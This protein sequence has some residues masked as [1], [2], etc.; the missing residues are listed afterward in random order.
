MKAMR[1]FILKHY[2]LKT[3]GDNHK[4][5]FSPPYRAT[6]TTVGEDGESPNVQS[7]GTTELDRHMY[8]RQISM[9]RRGDQNTADQQ[10]SLLQFRKSL[11]SYAKR[12]KILRT[13]EHHTITIICGP[14]G[15]GKT[16]QVPQF[17]LEDMIEALKG[18]KCSII[19]TQPRRISAVSVAERVAKERGE[20]IGSTTGYHIRLESRQSAQT[21]LL[22][23]TVGV[24]L[25]RLSDDP[26]LRQISHVIVDEVHERD[27]L[28]DFLL[29]VLRDLIISGKR[30]DLKIILMSATVDGDRFAEYFGSVVGADK[31]R[32]LSLEG[33]AFPVRGFFKEEVL[34]MLGGE[35]MAKICKRSPS[36][37][38]TPEQSE[39]KEEDI[40][41]NLISRTVFHICENFKSEGA[42]LIFL[43]GWKEITSLCQMINRNNPG[44]SIRVLPLHS[45]I[46]SYQQHQ[47][48]DVM[49][50]GWRKVVVATNIAE[51]SVT[52][53]DV[54]FVIDSGKVNQLSYNTALQMSLLTPQWISKAATKQREGRA[55]RCQ[56]GFVFRMFTSEQ[57]QAFPEYEVPEMVRTPLE[58]LCLQVKLQTDVDIGR[59][60]AKALDPPAQADIAR[61]VQLLVVLGALNHQGEL[62]HLGSQLARLPCHPRIGKM[63]LFG[64]VFNCLDPILTIACCLAHRS[65][66]I[67]PMPHE[68]QAAQKARQDF[69]RSSFSDQITALRAFNAWESLPIEERRAYSR[70][71]YL[72]HNTLTMIAGIKD[73]FRKALESLGFQ[74]EKGSSEVDKNI[75]M[76]RAIISSGMS[77]SVIEYTSKLTKKGMRVE[78]TFL[79]ESHKENVKIHPGSVNGM[80]PSTFM[81]P[82]RFVCYFQMMETSA[83][84]L[85]T[86]S[87][88]STLA[89]TIFSGDFDVDRVNLS[90]ECAGKQREDLQLSAFSNPT[91]YEI[92]KKSGKIPTDRWKKLIEELEHEE[93][94]DRKFSEVLDRVE[95]M[96]VQ[97]QEEKVFEKKKQKERQREKEAKE[98]KRKQERLKQKEAKRKQIEE[99]NESWFKHFDES[100]DRAA[101]AENG[102]PGDE[103]EE[104]ADTEGTND[105]TYSKAREFMCTG[106]SASP[107]NSDPPFMTSSCASISSRVGTVIL[108]DRLNPLSSTFPSPGTN[109]E[110]HELTVDDLV[111]DMEQA[112]EDECAHQEEESE[113]EEDGEDEKSFTV[114]EL[115][116][117]DPYDTVAADDEGAEEEGEFEDDDD[118]EGDDSDSDSDSNMEECSEVSEEE[119]QKRRDIDDDWHDDAE[120][121]PDEN[122]H[123]DPTKFDGENSFIEAMADLIAL[124]IQDSMDDEER[125]G[126]SP[127]C[128][129]QFFED[130]TPSCPPSRSSSLRQRQD[131]SVVMVNNFVEIRMPPQT[132]ECL[133][134]IAEA[135]QEFIVARTRSPQPTTLTTQ[136]QNG[137]SGKIWSPA[138]DEA[139][140]LPLL[141]MLLKKHDHC[142]SGTKATLRQR[143]RQAKQAPKARKRM[144]KR[145]KQ[146][147]PNKARHLRT[148]GTE[149]KSPAAGKGGS[150]QF[151]R[152]RDTKN[153]LGG[154]K[155]RRNEESATTEH[156]RRPSRGNGGPPSRSLKKRLNKRLKKRKLMKSNKRG[157]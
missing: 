29:I 127:V 106:P 139:G 107:T 7:T 124:E 27:R 11:P 2:S 141:Q 68:R 34:Q 155:R 79:T 75:S 94:R 134:Y 8:E 157:K 57:Y 55:G 73:Q 45:S 112:D 90:R 5:M 54:V 135:T 50:Q 70:Q 22:F 97:R 128:R 66:F 58:E 92:K 120:V 47:V 42:I 153:S 85:R 37:V 77:P 24:L 100:A 114:D 125:E 95:S 31:V 138:D 122:D 133:A 96:A 104:E 118:Y 123:L 74:A 109:E 36:P 12:S 103:H 81:F 108:S 149:L 26:L 147:S 151:N 132:K 129:T 86:T 69:D 40:D 72:S 140:L 121:S 89:L 80:K 146:R 67:L 10:L 143:Q 16:T 49:P 14:T 110:K 148:L 82:E 142:L 98:R 144:S 3:K 33:R 111:E 1:T 38:Q 71:N 30:P 20:P 78:T 18:S 13:I 93:E 39:L 21:R 43:P 126:V 115:K 113:P 41:L 76:L 130:D 88:V 87:V 4:A 145:G 150:S 51:T 152:R 6:G 91:D 46:P 59:F 101:T 99:Q 25:R 83:L 35:P 53:D 84:Y 60:L 64:A 48:F 137:V 56:P 28:A 9:D 63:I 116:V 61:T 131:Y 136:N 102:E 32:I 17:I 15:C 154:T 19:T 23:C 44:F 117:E 62:T 52:I 156:R 119:E 105:S 65:P